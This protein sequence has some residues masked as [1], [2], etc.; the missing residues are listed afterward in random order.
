M[1]YV[2]KGIHALFSI[3]IAALFTHTITPASSAQ[4]SFQSLAVLYAATTILSLSAAKFKA[5]CL[6]RQPMILA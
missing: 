1:N 4:A 3:L 6:P 5:F 2:Q